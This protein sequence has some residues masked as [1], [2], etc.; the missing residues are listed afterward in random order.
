MWHRHRA[1]LILSA[2]LALLASRQ[3][4]GQAINGNASSFRS[5]GSSSGSDLVLNDNGYVG[6]FFTLN[7]PAEVTF[8]V[9]A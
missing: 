2:I 7:A 1:L 5:S 9:N 4:G 3:A 8:Q 6:T